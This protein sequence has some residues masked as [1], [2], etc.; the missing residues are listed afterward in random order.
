VKRFEKKVA[1]RVARG[2]LTSLGLERVVDP[3]ACGFELEELARAAVE[4]FEGAEQ[5]LALAANRLIADFASVVAEGYVPTSVIFDRNVEITGDKAAAS[6][7]VPPVLASAGNDAIRRCHKAH[8][9]MAASIR[10][11]A[12][13]ALDALAAAIDAAAPSN[14]RDAAQSILDDLI[15]LSQRIALAEQQ[16][17]AHLMPTLR[18][19]IVEVE[20]PRHPAALRA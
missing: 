9:T 2:T 8:A 10:I 7:L 4:P 14:E 5:L 6:D 19:S 11:A 16:P 12:S 20:R 18:A 1:I 13:K 3:S 15:E 17:F